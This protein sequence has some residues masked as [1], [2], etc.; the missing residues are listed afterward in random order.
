MTVLRKTEQ[1]LFKARAHLGNS[2]KGGVAFLHSLE[3]VAE[4]GIEVFQC[5]DRVCRG[6]LFSAR[7]HARIRRHLEEEGTLLVWS[8]VRV[9][10]YRTE[11]QRGAGELKE[12]ATENGFNKT[13]GSN[14]QRK[15]QAIHAK[16]ELTIRYRDVTQHFCRV[17][18]ATPDGRF[19]T[20]GTR[21]LS[22]F[23]SE[24]W[25]CYTSSSCRRRRDA[26]PLLI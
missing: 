24:L 6:T 3:T 23:S 10:T 1:C 5:T 21:S 12:A 13:T 15:T 19:H 14:D 7:G 26:R 9:L 20:R 8:S 4:E 11:A 22:C 18:F 17:G 16:P 25:P 2:V